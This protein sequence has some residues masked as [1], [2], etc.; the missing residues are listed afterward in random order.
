MGS[1]MCFVLGSNQ[2]ES[3]GSRN[4]GARGKDLRTHAT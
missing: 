1:K 2:L 3:G 4:L